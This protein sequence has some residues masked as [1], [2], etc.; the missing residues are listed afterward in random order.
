LKAAANPVIV[1]P[2]HSAGVNDLS[3]NNCATCQ[4]RLAPPHSKAHP[5]MREMRRA[6]RTC[7]LPKSE[8]LASCLASPEFTDL[9][10]LLTFNHLM[11]LAEDAA[12][13][14]AWALASA[15]PAVSASR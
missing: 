14:A 10:T 15:F 9:V 6:E 8:G 7:P 11:G 1:I 12:F 5:L 2:H 13:R 4:K 3:Y